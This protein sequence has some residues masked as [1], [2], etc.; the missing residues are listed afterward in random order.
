M[1]CDCPSNTTVCIRAEID[2]KTSIKHADSSRFFN[3]CTKRSH[4]FSARHI[5]I[6]MHD[7]RMTVTTFESQRDLSLLSTIESHSRL[8]EPLNFARSF[9]D[10][11]SHSRR[12]AKSHSSNHR[13]AKVC[14]RRIIFIK[15]CGDS[16]LRPLRVR[17]IHRSLR[18]HKDIAV[19]CGFECCTHSCDATSNDQRVGKKLREQLTAK[20]NE[21]STLVKDAHGDFFVDGVVDEAAGETK[22]AIHN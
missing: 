9:F 10:Q 6:G 13:V 21:I 11:S 3:R 4:Q 2:C 7:A 8:N 22:S 20:R 5:A 12:F 15:C 18:K 14:L 16:T 17:K 1:P 19:N